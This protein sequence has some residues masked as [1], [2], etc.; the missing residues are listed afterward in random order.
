M[1]ISWQEV[2]AVE[3]AGTLY[4]TLFGQFAIRCGE[5]DIL[6]DVFCC[7]HGQPRVDAAHQGNAYGIRQGEKTGGKADLPQSRRGV[8]ARP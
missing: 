5:G 6:G 3:H 2:N 1:W 8:S 4:V 7:Q